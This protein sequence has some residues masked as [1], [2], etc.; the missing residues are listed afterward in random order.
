M[1][2][3][4]KKKKQETRNRILTA[5]ISLFAK[6][7]IKDTSTLDIALNSKVAHGTI[8][9][10]FP[11]RNRLITETVDYFGKIL[12]E[13]I[14]ILST[15]KKGL[16]LM[17]ESHIKILKEFETFYSR[18]IMERHLLPVETSDI[19]IALQSSVSHHFF[20]AAERETAAGKIR[21][22]PNHLLFNTWIGLVHYYIANSDLFSPGGS[23]LEQ[24][25]DELINHFLNLI[26]S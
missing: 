14:H 15:G 23:V 10:H 21:K 4:R 13:K 12:S 5:A 17:L 20:I 3:S 22:I 1:R 18:L 25:G 24:K 16:R 7:G 19:F 11:S 6:N 9:V 2:I 8:F 26:I